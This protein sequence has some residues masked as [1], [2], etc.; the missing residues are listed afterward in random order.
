MMSWTDFLILYAIL[1]TTMV[2]SRC[3][4][5]F[6]LRGRTLSQ[7]VVDVLGLIPVAAFAALVANDLFQPALWTTQEIWPTLVPLIAG[8][9]V[10]VVAKRTGS[11]VGC[12]LTGVALY[13]ALGLL[14]F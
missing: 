6:V 8:A 2:L 13:F 7:G 3:V 5:L 1:M 10:V 9:C 12:A 11:L 4:P 14:P